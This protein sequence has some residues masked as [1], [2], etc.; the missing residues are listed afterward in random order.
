M[1]T[2]KA[3]I[4]RISNWFAIHTALNRYA[5]TTRI[6]TVPTDLSLITARPGAIIHVR[7]TTVTFMCTESTKFGLSLQRYEPILYLIKALP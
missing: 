4:F 1:A 2:A 5:E 6:A 3:A 7:D